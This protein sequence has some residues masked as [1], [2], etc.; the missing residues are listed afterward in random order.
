MSVS[1]IFPSSA[2]NLVN[3]LQNANQQQRAEFQQFAQALRSGD[4]TNAQQA[5]GALTKNATGSG[6]QSVQL[7]QDLHALGSALQSGDA[8]GARDAYS[9]LQQ[10]FHN[11]NPLAAHHHRPHYGGGGLRVFTSGFSGMPVTRESLTPV[12]AKSSARST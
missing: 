2:L 12:K 9:A 5:L 6:L 1:A 10:V 11:S 4:L 8:A 3:N 7:T